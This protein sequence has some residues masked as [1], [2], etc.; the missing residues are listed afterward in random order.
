MMATFFDYIVGKLFSSEKSKITHKENFKQKKVEEEEV[1][2]WL[3]SQ[4]GKSVLELIH[5]NYHFK[6]S[7]INASPQIH[8]LKSPYANGF[9]ITF[10]EPL[11]VKQFDYLFHGLGKIIL[12][13]QYYQV[14]LDRKIEENNDQVKITEKIYLKPIV[15]QFELT[16]K[17]D[18]RYGNIAIEKISDGRKPSYLKV[19][20]TI[21]QDHLYRKPLPFDQFIEDLFQ[22]RLS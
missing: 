1:K 20:V 10:E 2:E 15:D 12:N 8:L 22:T 19:L 13:L 17:I 21:Y 14:S 4:E 16:Q 11:T 7:G 3:H 6:T 18:Q 9:A 5:K